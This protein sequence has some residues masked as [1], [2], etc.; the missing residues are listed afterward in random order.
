MRQQQEKSK[1]KNNS[2]PATVTVTNYFGRQQIVHQP[3]VCM[4]HTASGPRATTS[5]LPPLYLE[6]CCFGLD[7]GNP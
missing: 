3:D 2:L 7:G 6:T 5:T 1:K 4:S